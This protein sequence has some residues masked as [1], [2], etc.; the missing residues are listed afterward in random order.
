MICFGLEG[1]SVCIISMPLR[2]DDI[3]IQQSALLSVFILYLWCKFEY[4]FAKMFM[5]WVIWGVKVT[6][7][8]IYNGFW[9]GTGF[10]ALVFS[11][12][13]WVFGGLTKI[14]LHI[15]Y[16]CLLIIYSLIVYSHS[17]ANYYNSNFQ[18][19]VFL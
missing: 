12:Q 13:F 1:E 10:S 8:W 3:I 17:L 7:N 19:K 6:L 4:V 11:Q 18:E 16:T 15:V 14:Q 9:F 2:Y 5:K